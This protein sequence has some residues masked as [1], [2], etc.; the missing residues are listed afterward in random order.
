MNSGRPGRLTA[1]RSTSTRITGWRLRP[2]GRTGLPATGVTARPAG[3][4]VAFA[5]GAGECAPRLD[6]DRA[7]LVFHARR[8]APDPAPAGGS[9]ARR[10]RGARDRRRSRV[11]AGAPHGRR[12]P[13]SPPSA[14]MVWLA[15]WF[16]NAHL[17]HDAVVPQPARYRRWP[18]LRGLGPLGRLLVP[19]DRPRGLR[20]LP[21]RAVV[22]GLLAVVPDRGQGVQLAVPEH[23]HHRLGRHP[24]ERRH[25]GG[26]LPALGRSV[27]EAGRRAR[28]RCSCCWSSR[29][30]TTSTAPSTP[31][32]C[33]SPPP[34]A[35]SCCSNATRSSGPGSSASSPPPGVRRG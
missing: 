11:A 28:R 22:G 33:S 21:G 32:P 9:S 2:V 25:A 35:P 16:G 1:T 24:G 29:T 17:G 6:R 4:G 18:V 3:E 27:P 10:V 19:H 14:R 26:L 20:L 13:C 34:S 23:L 5:P 31:T 30:A 8:A 12:W 7:S 15:I